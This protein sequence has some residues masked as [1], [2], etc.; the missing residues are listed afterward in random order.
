[1]LGRVRGGDARAL[2]GRRCDGS[3]RISLSVRRSSCC[4]LSAKRLRRA[5]PEGG[6]GTSDDEVEVRWEG[7]RVF[8]CPGA[9]DANPPALARMR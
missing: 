2:H 7:G 6:N 1:M 8:G 3:I 9:I 4:R 5:R